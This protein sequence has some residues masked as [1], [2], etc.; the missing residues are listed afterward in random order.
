MFRHAGFDKRSLEK[1][2]T[3]IPLLFMK[4]A[5]YWTFDEFGGG[6]KE[7]VAALPKFRCYCRACWF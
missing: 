7:L 1:Q 6:A 5:R 2:M 3:V 4:M